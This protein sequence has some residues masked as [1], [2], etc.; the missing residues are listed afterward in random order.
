MIYMELANCLGTPVT[1]TGDRLSFRFINSP[2]VRICRHAIKAG[3]GQ[4]PAKNTINWQ[5]SEHEGLYLR[6]L[7]ETKLKLTKWSYLHLSFF[8]VYPTHPSQQSGQSQLTVCEACFVPKFPLIF[9]LLGIRPRPIKCTSLHCPGN[10]VVLSCLV[11]RAN[12]TF[13]QILQIT[14]E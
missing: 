3:T 13:L 11:R 8:V 5:I 12:I 4:N 10:R 6:K 1:L 9:H 2:R 14:N 7:G